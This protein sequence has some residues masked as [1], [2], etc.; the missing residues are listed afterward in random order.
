MRKLRRNQSGRENVRGKDY[1][2]VSLCCLGQIEQK[3]AR[4]PLLPALSLF[5]KAG[6]TLEKKKFKRRTKD[7][8]F[9]FL[10]RLVAASHATQ[11]I[12]ALRVKNQRFLPRYL[13]T[14]QWRN[15]D[16]PCARANHPKLSNYSIKTTMFTF[17]CLGNTRAYPLVRPL[18]LF[19]LW[20]SNGSKYYIETVDHMK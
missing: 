12:P 14:L 2:C 9:I 15:Q 10:I 11:L 5:D 1:L 18:V 8:S 17:R 3:N 13:G 19:V 7:F 16:P 6:T 20:I 4:F